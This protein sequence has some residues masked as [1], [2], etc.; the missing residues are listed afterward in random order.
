MHCKSNFVKITLIFY[1]IV[2]FIHARL[3]FIN[4]ENI[5]FVRMIADA[6]AKMAPS[7]RSKL[8]NTHLN[9]KIAPPEP[10]PNSKISRMCIIK[11]QIQTI[12]F[13]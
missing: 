6:L 8:Y 7:F 1:D 2:R 5:Y 11:D 9:F 3:I 10:S 12:S 13:M 4:G